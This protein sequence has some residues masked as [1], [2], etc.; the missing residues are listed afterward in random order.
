MAGLEIGGWF[1]SIF[2]ARLAD[3]VGSYI[4]KQLKYQKGAKT[5]LN[6]L[7][8][9]LRKIHAVIHAT[10]LGRYQRAAHLEAWL[11]ELRD[12]AFEAED[13]LDGFEYQILR[14]TA[15]GKHKIVATIGNFPLPSHLGAQ[16]QQHGVLFADAQRDVPE[17]RETTSIM[18]ESEV[19]GREHE[20]NSLVRLL[21]KPDVASRSNNERFSVVSILGIGGVGKT[22]VAQ[23]VYNDSQI[24]DHFDV[25]LWVHVSEKFDVRRLTREMLESVCRDSRH[26]LTNL[27]TLQ[28]ILKDKQFLIVLDDVWNEVRSRWETLRKPFQFGKQGSRVLVTSRIPM[29]ANNMGTRAT[30]ILKGLNG[31]DYRKFFERCAFGD[32]NPDDHPKLKLI[33]ERIANK[34]VGSP[35]AAKTVGGAL[36]SKLEEDHWRSI[37]E[38]K[39]WQMQQ[40]EDDIFPALR[41][42]YEHLPTSALKQC[43]LYF[44]LF[45]KNYCFEKD[46]LVR[47]WMAQGFLQ[48]GEPGRRPEDVGE[49]YF[50]ELLHRSLFQDSMNGGQSGKY[51]VHDLLH[52]LAESLSA[53]EYCRVEDDESEEIPERVCHV[54]VSS[55]N[56]AKLY[57]T[58]PKLKNLRSL[59]VNGSLLDTVAKSKLMEFLKVTLKRLKRLRVIVID[60]LVLDVLP[61]GIGH[62]RHLRYLEVPGDQLIDLPKWI[63][64]L[65]QLQG[66]SLQFR[67]PLLHLGRPLPRGIHRLVN[68]RYLNIN[69]EKV[70]TIFK[71]G[72]LRSLQELREF[73]VRKGNGYELGQLRDMRQLRGQLSIMNLDMAGSASECRAAELDNKEHLSAL[74][75]Y[76]GQL[77]R[78]GIDKHEEVLEALRPHRNLSELRIIGYMGTKSPSWLETSWLSNLEHIELEDCQ[79]WEVLPPL[80]QLPFLKIL[81]LK[82]LKLVKN[83][84]SEFYGGHSIAFPLL[85]E[86]LFSD[87]GEWR[88]WS[89]AKAS[90][91]LFPRLRR[92]QIDRCHKLRGSLVLP[93]VLE[94]LHIVLSD[95]VTWESYEKPHVVLSDDVIWESS[96]TNDIS[97]I[98]KLSIDNISLLTDCLPAECLP[99][100]YR[101]DVVYCSSLESFT[102]EQE[103][104]L[105]RL[106]SLEEL[107]FSDCDN[108]TR[109]PTD[110]NSLALLKTL[111]IEGLNFEG[112]HLLHLMRL[113]IPNM[114]NPYH[115]DHPKRFLQESRVQEAHD[116]YHQ[117][118]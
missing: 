101:L 95:D 22:T 76:W 108:L 43:F 21:L 110:L 15:K 78:K 74:H 16:N 53:H 114:I 102:D 88:Q 66:L 47:M 34:L 113:S 94:R 11:W 41:L 87:M 70:S 27:D 92:L 86:L 29:V 64:R 65:Y 50:D 54:Y 17:W 42:S 105:Q 115:F 62:M 112:Y 36:K 63:C 30:V 1:A 61:E 44:A 60:G 82:S 103:K 32:V 81:H 31:A 93:T 28:G 68:I 52:H 72:K 38:S 4:G 100:L 6:Q 35:L 98:L 7:E 80:G 75:L 49:D 90:S 10:D 39:L 9:N 67:S 14:D 96:E 69:P 3:Q 89:G 73:H 59:V 51:V 19:L 45:P 109:L 77:G 23:C 8:A 18:N 58:A 56:L 117:N 107:R 99:S 79:G 2:L 84:F 71:I 55:S 20:I 46:R 104:W 33:G 12:A 24:D 116:K 57:E 91:Q 13:L 48:P 111:H 26:H 83:I 37:M 25:K 40:K 85:E 97:S 106:S 118:L 5:K